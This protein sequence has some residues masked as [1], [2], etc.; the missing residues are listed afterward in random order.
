ME[1]NGKYLFIRNHQMG[2]VSWGRANFP[3]FYFRQCVLMLACVYPKVES[4]E[5]RIGEAEN[6]QD[7]YKDSSL[8][9]RVPR[10]INSK[11]VLRA[12]ALVA[13]SHQPKCHMWW[14]WLLKLCY[15]ALQL[16]CLWSLAPQQFPDT[17]RQAC[18]STTKKDAWHPLFPSEHN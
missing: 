15:W 18:V 3:Q 12:L 1:L 10:E 4:G 13:H 14:R 11:V 6:H 17:H 9:T 8:N 16:S 5:E 2:Q 7:R